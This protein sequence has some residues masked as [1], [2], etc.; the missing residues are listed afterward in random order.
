LWDRFLAPFV[1]V[2][3]AVFLFIYFDK[4]DSHWPEVMPQP[5][6]SL[7]SFAEDLGS[8]PSTHMA[9]HNHLWPQS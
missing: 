7:A 1:V 5:L 4:R 6:T 3:A 8:I 9:A 2:A